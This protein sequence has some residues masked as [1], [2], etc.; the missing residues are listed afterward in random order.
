MGLPTLR[1]RTGRFE[2]S[3]L[4]QY[5]QYECSS[6]VILDKRTGDWLL[7]FPRRA[8][9][10]VGMT[11]RCKHLTARASWKSRQN[12]CPLRRRAEQRRESPPKEQVP[13]QTLG[14]AARKVPDG[15]A[16]GMNDQLVR[17]CL[18]L[19]GS[20]SKLLGAP[21]SLVAAPSPT[22]RWEM[23]SSWQAV[24]RRSFSVLV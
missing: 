3:G 24:S 10:F 23:P 8:C 5:T 16:G 20:L 9:C 18:V 6:R 15:K 14:K 12:P 4:A 21:G 17:L 7:I 11:V 19:H 1:F 22:V 13:G 2:G